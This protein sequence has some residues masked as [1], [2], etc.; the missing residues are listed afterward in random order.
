MEINMVSHVLLD[1]FKTIFWLKNMAMIS[2]VHILKFN[3]VG[4]NARGEAL[5]S[6]NPLMNKN[7]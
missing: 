1:F 3:R 6:D 5:D 2:D 4:S 7:R